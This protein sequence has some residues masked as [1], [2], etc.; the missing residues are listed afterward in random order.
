[1]P[2][3]FWLGVGAGTVAAVPAPTAAGSAGAGASTRLQAPDEKRSIS[4]RARTNARKILRG[5]IMSGSSLSETNADAQMMGCV[6]YWR[7]PPE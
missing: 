1:M 7:E 6:D 3:T 2:L 4:G 5:V